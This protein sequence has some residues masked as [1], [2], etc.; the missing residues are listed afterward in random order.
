MGTASIFCSGM[1][2][3]RYHEPG[4][5]CCMMVLFVLDVYHSGSDGAR[6]LCVRNASVFVC[7]LIVCQFV[8]VR[9]LFALAH[10]VCVSIEHESA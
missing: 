9:S 4:W 2:Q 8:C 10:I 5:W 1:P 3:G 7:S 6:C